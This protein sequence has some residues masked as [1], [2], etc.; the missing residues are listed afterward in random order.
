MARKYFSRMMTY[1]QASRNNR[2]N[3]VALQSIIRQKK[4]EKK[5]C[6]QKNV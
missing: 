6:L 5:V 1:M 2:E 3:N 4:E